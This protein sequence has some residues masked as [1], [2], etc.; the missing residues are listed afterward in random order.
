MT[1]IINISVNPGREYRITLPAG[2]TASYNGEA[3]SSYFIAVEGVNTLTLS[4]NSVESGSITVSEILR[5]FYEAYDG[6]GGV[7]CFQPSLDKWTSMYSFR[8]EWMSIVGNRLVTF[9]SGYPYIHDGTYNTFYGQ[10]Y[11]S[12]LAFVHNES[13]NSTKVYE[14]LS[15]EGDT[16][17]LVHV[18]TEVP[19]VQS[20]DLRSADFRINE[21]VKYAPIL[22]DR[23]SPNT[24]GTYDQKVY[25]GDMVRGDIGLFQGVFFTPSTKKIWKFVNLGF[26]P[27]RGHNT[28]NTQ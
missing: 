25:A 7:W 1:T 23:L 24:A 18:R 28:Q 14:S 13:G 16:P 21:G 10:T 2:V 17:D 15:I 9:K 6:Y 5:N 26:I 20:S 8:P 12:V 19:Y 4:S 3:I 11:D 27:S 22:R